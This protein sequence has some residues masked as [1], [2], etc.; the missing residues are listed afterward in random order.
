MRSASSLLAAG[1]TGAAMM[2]ASAQAAT[3]ELVGTSGF[4]VEPVDDFESYPP[5]P[6]PDQH[7]DFQRI[8]LHSIVV[9]PQGNVFATA[10]NAENAS[11][12]GGVTIYKA[13]GGQ[14][15][16][17]FNPSF[18]GGPTKLVVGGDGHVYGLLNWSEIAF[19]FARGYDH[20][21]VRISIDPGGTSATVTTVFNARE[22]V[23]S[24]GVAPNV[25]HDQ[26]HGMTTASDGN[27]Y[28]WVGGH[29][30]NYWKNHNFFR[31]NRFTNQIEESG[32][33][34]TL[35]GFDTERLL[36]LEWVGF[37]AAI[38]EDRFIVFNDGAASWAAD[39]ILWSGG[40]RTGA[41]PNAISNPGHGRD[42]ITATAYDPVNKKL[43]A[44]GRGSFG[45]PS[46]GCDH[47]LEGGVAGP[48]CEGTNIMSRWNGNPANPGALLTGNPIEPSSIL[49]PTIN[50]GSGADIWHTNGNCPD[51]PDGI[52]NGGPYWVTTIAVSPCDG[53][54]W[55][56]WGGNRLYSTNGGVSP[57]RYGTYGYEKEGWEENYGATG[58]YGPMGVV[59]TVGKDGQITT[60]GGNEGAPLAPKTSQVVALTFAN[61]GRRVYANVYDHITGQ[62][63]VYKADL[64]NAGCCNDPAADVEPAQV[65]DG[66]VD[67]DDFGVFQECYKASPLPDS[68]LCLDFNKDGQVNDSDF[69]RF[70]NCRSGPSI[71][72]NPACDD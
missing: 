1:L 10:G 13:D 37:D 64:E 66:D 2:A 36:N 29:Q 61:N 71:P 70:M 3:W 65:G 40:G 62:F 20:R 7:R 28:F 16:V 51:C 55:M 5:W 63:R 27:I 39:S 67:H 54:A 25:E 69:T 19:G 57:Q 23:L 17:N 59:Y 12:A 18:P 60:A 72:A 41:Y 4:T 31:Y 9:D 14:I 34:G 22:W 48:L 50:A 52:T 35:T 43:W 24:Q 33:A 6:A 45:G 46:S 56:S 21:I 68:C 44:A 53:K 58:E 15:D 42:W 47:E 8:R 49:P 30:S 32:N 26:I 38:N 11:G